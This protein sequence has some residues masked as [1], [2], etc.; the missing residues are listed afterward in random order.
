VE[1]SLIDSEEEKSPSKC[2]I[3]QSRPEYEYSPGENPFNKRSK[4]QQEVCPFRMSPEVELKRSDKSQDTTTNFC[5]EF[6]H[7]KLSP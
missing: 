4:L 6:E 1:I 7:I 2:N 5:T 3:S